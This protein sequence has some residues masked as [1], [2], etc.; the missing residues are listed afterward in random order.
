MPEYVRTRTL[1]EGL[2]SGSFTRSAIGYSNASSAFTKKDYSQDVVTWSPRKSGKPLT[3]KKNRLLGG[4]ISGSA[5]QTRSYNQWLP[6][7][8]RSIDAPKFQSHIPNPQRPTDAS[9]VTKLIASANPESGRTNVP[10]FAFELREFPKLLSEAKSWVTSP[11][12]HFSPGQLA[13]YNLGNQFGWKP[14]VQDLYRMLTCMES[15]NKRAIL[16]RRIYDKG[17]KVFER[18]LFNGYMPSKYLGR[19]TVH[20]TG[21][22]IIYSDEYLKYTKQIVRGY[23]EYRP[24]APPPTTSRE[25]FRHAWKTYHSL[26]LNPQTLWD[27]MPWSWFVDYFLN[28]GDYVGANSGNYNFRLHE[29]ALMEDIQTLFQGD[30]FASTSTELPSPRVFYY[31]NEYTE[32]RRWTPPI[33]IDT[34]FGTPFLTGYQTSILGSLVTAKFFK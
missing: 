34:H 21:G 12:S 28:V 29:Y 15:I 16:H 10:L 14:V 1:N 32:R 19:A 24:V 20:S 31:K 25:L 11:K 8:Y 3:L 30:V 33:T 9:L 7:P 17:G 6:A 18:D 23:A 4:F 5:I 26:R 22:T 27:A 13:K 2:T